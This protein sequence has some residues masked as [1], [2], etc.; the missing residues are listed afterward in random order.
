VTVAADNPVVGS[1]ASPSTPIPTAA[2]GRLVVPP[3]DAGPWVLTQIERGMAIRKTRIRTTDDLDKAR[4]RK[5][6]W[7]K[8]TFDLLAGMFDND[9]VAQDFNTWDARVLP[10][11]VDLKEFAEIFYDEMN[12]RLTKLKSIHRR[13]PP[14]VTPPAGAPAPSPVAQ[15]TT[16][17]SVT[18]TTI[19]TSTEEMPVNSPAPASVTPAADPSSLP[20]TAGQT[21]CLLIVAD[22]DAGAATG[23]VAQL[24]SKLGFQAHQVEGHGPSRS[25][26][27]GA[28]AVFLSKAP[29][30][31]QMAYH[32]G[33]CAAKCGAD[34][35]MVLT[36]EPA[37]WS[38]C[39]LPVSVIQLD[40]SELWQ[41][42]LA[43]QLRRSG[44]D[45][46]MNRLC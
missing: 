9:A 6:E 10:D 20:A 13:I 32:L 21:R 27:P 39:D 8:Q 22:A 14:A 38:G 15:T 12:Q 36:P 16:R 29:P 17:T 33:F 23:Q 24:L 4:A 7:V 41:F 46:D 1:P 11:Y 35:L 40:H 30:N 25:H 18:T 28:F 19:E 44:V 26:S 2:A 34:R 31:A 37:A 42:Q 43:R 3:G 45:L 5:T